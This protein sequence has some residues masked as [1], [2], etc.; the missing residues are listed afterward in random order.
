M[1][2]RSLLASWIKSLWTDE[3]LRPWVDE[4]RDWLEKQYKSADA[5]LRTCL[6]QATLEH[7]FEV[8]GIAERFAG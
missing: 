8:E 5:E 4:F 7:L 1:E 3:L 6:V 2:R